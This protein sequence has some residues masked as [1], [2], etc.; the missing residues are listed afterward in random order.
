[1]PTYL[2]QFGVNFRLIRSEEDFETL[3]VFRNM[4][5]VR[6]EMF[7]KNEISKDAHNKWVNSLNLDKNFYFIYDVNSEDIGVVNIKNIDF[8]KKDGEYGIFV[9]NK[10]FLG[11]H[12]NIAAVLFIYEYAFNK[13]GLD[14]LQAHIIPTNGKAIRMNTSLGFKLVDSEHHRYILVKSDYL[15][16]KNRFER[17]FTR[18]PSKI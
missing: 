18:T 10:K 15:N 16:V 13:I 7:Y 11:S 6:S 4:Q 9:A 14:R 12:L 2:T 8:F 1:M 17:L 5:H 3:R